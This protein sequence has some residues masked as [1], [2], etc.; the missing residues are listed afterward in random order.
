MPTT[1]KQLR[2]F[3]ALL[4][5]NLEVKVIKEY[6][7]GLGMG[8]GTEMT[9]LELPDKYGYSENLNIYDDQLWLGER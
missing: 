1:V 3:L 4:P 7:A 9:D 6:Y 2:D 5:D 8:F